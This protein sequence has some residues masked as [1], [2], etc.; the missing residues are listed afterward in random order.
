MCAWQA[1]RVIV[2]GLARGADLPALADL[3]RVGWEDLTR[4]PGIG[5]KTAKFFVLH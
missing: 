5:I 3:R 4:F 1:D 2:M